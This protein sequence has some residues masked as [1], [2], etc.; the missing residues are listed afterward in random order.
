MSDEPTVPDA[1]FVPAEP[2]APP[3]VIVTLTARGEEIGTNI[4]PSQ[5]PLIY[6]LLSRACL[7]VLTQV[8][9]QEKATLVKPNGMSGLLKRMG[10]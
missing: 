1:V 7:T 10:R 9:E 5:R 6:W 3:H 4:P 2:P 8:S